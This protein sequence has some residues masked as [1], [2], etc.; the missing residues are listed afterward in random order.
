VS[1][2][3]LKLSHKK[4]KPTRGALEEVLEIPAGGASPRGSTYYKTFQHC[5]REFYIRYVLGWVPTVPSEA[6]TTGLVWHYCLERYYRGIMSHQQKTRVQPT[7]AAWL[8]GGCNQGAAE[9]YALIDKLMAAPGYHEIAQ[10]VRRM[11]DAYLDVYDRQDKLRVLAV[12][13]TLEWHGT[14]PYT[15]RAD[16]IVEDY[17][18]GGMWFW[19]HKSARAITDDLLA[20]YDMDLQILGEWWLLDRVVDRTVYPPLRGVVINLATKAKE[21]KLHRHDVCPSPAHVRAF[22][23]TIGTRK[24]MLQAAAK[25][26]WPQW[27]GNCSGAARGYSR[28]AY[29][30]LCQQNP[31]HDAAGL[32]RE[33]VAS[34][35]EYAQ[36]NGDSD[37]DRY[38]S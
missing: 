37:Y 29:Y 25:C 4:A 17:I 22:E 3:V 35:P 8:W 18:R 28:C 11:L 7:S 30:E 14:D 31:Q 38:S 21:P 15:C 34:F 23:R 5:P 32:A 1:R 36:A 13:E 19:E 2:I 24:V 27:F 33:G 20:A 26:G 6:L 9:A 12:E 16:M 10:T